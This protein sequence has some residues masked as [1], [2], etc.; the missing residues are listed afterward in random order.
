MSFRK[1]FVLLGSALAAFLTASLIAPAC[2]ADGLPGTIRHGAAAIEALGLDGKAHSLPAGSARATLLI[3]VLHDCPV[4]NRYAPEISRIAAEYGK[5]NV[6]SYVVYEE[7]DLTPAQARR[8]AKAY[9]LTCGLL[10]DPAHDL[11]RQVGAVATPE[12]VLLSPGREIVYHG[13]IDDT[14]RHFGMANPAPTTRDLRA[15]LD[16]FLAGTPVAVTETPVVGCAIPR[17]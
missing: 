8:H 17:D 13:R 6:A 11:A 1:R 2:R 5:R 14:F 4:C 16:S 15:A 3:F 10:Y 7:R 9:G 12:A